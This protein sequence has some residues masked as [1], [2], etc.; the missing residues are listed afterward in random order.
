MGPYIRRCIMLYNATQSKSG[1]MGNISDSLQTENVST[2]KVQVCWGILAS[3]TA[4]CCENITSG[5]SRLLKQI[6][7]VAYNVTGLY[8][9][10]M[11]W[12]H[13]EDT[14]TISCWLS[15][16]QGDSRQHSGRRGMQCAWAPYPHQHRATPPEPSAP[17]PPPPAAQSPP[18]RPETQ[19][20][21][22]PQHM[23]YASLRLYA[24]TPIPTPNPNS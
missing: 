7:L 17:A 8:N 3:S 2:N 16:V 15:R 11:S 10:C 22:H 4:T 5:T 12:L 9:T 14:T 13:D 20:C 19:G 18:M 24:Q 1:Y 6:D 23:A 21:S